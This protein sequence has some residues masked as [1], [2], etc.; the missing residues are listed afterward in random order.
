MRYIE[1]RIFHWRNKIC[2]SN[3]STLMDIN[4]FSQISKHFV[5]ALTRLLSPSEWRVY[6]VFCC[7]GK[8][9]CVLQTTSK[10]RLDCYYFNFYECHSNMTKNIK[11]LDPI[12]F[13]CTFVRI[14]IVCDNFKKYNLQNILQIYSNSKVLNVYSKVHILIIYHLVF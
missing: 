3:T 4:C 11:I 9:V 2:F 13:K 14:F 8:T 6:K 12:F 5:L 1:L 7:W 10:V